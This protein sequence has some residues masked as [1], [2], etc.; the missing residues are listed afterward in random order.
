MLRNVLL[1]FALLISGALADV[2]QTCT[3][4]DGSVAQ[5]Y[6]PCGNSTATSGPCCLEG[7]TCTENGL[8][9]GSVGLVYRGA[10]IN[11]WGGDCLTYCDDSKLFY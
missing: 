4:K 6:L 10:C 3:W 8:C 2:I 7:E 5:N 9:Y 1:G 11:E